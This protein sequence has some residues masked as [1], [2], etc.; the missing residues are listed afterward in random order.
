MKNFKRVLSVVLAVLL[1]T[2]VFVSCK[3]DEK[4]ASSTV[5]PS[6]S[7]E[8]SKSEEPSAPAEPAGQVIIGTDTEPNGDWAYG[9]FASSINATDQSVLF[10]TDDC[11]TVTTN[12]AGDYLIDPTIV[13]DYKREE[14]ADGNVT[15]TIKIRQGLVFNNGDP[16][17]AE[18][19]LAWPLFTMSKAG[20]DMG[21]TVITDSTPGG[22]DYREGK[23]NYLEGLR[24]LGDYEF[25][26]KTLAV[27]YSGNEYLPYYFDITMASARA[28][29]LDYWFGEGWTVKDDGQGAYLYNPDKELTKESVGDQVVAAQYATSDR[30]TA[31]PYNLVNFDKG[32]TEITLEVNPN[33]CGTFEGRKPMIKKVII[34]R[35]NEET[36]I[37]ELST[38][39]VEL[40]SSMADGKLV[41]SSLDLIDS[42]KFDGNY[43]SY[44]RAGYGQLV[45]ACDLG[46]AQYV[47]FR[48]AIAYLLDRNEFANTFC[49][50]WGGVVHG[51][52]CPAFTMY[53]DSRDLFAEKLNSYDFN[54]EKAVEL[55]KTA[56]FVFNA[57]G[58][59]YVDGSG[60]LRYKE[61]TEE[62][63]T[64][65]DEFVVKA[66]GKILMPALINWCSSEGNEVSDLLAT[67][68]A[69]G[70]ETKKAGIQIKQNIMSFPELLNYYY[71]QDVY[72][73]GGDYSV[74]TYNMFN[75]GTGF[76]A[77]YDMS[78]EFTTDP[79]WQ[80]EGYNTSHIN[81]EQ[82]DKLSMNMVYGVEA[83]DYA[84][85]LKTWQDFIIRFNEML[86]QIPLYANV[87]V[88]VYPN[89]IENYVEYPFW[90]FDRAIVYADYV[91]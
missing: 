32:A 38:G 48:Q 6:K 17:K 41:N 54:P 31:G 39:R 37:D 23:V 73:L 82:L 63:A 29:N 75:M 61:V 1:M 3:K 89:T 40:Y 68:L 4:P 43:T 85:Y 76:N 87:Y 42:G 44:D 46:P 8:P 7:A 24:L 62:E 57:D 78:Y 74:P 15:Y 88:S 69:N 45:F 19:F 67:M 30:V 5:E 80:A 11:K 26:I 28:V 64:H 83:G 52:Y 20:A 91:G 49:Q 66:G 14:D 86:P 58:T 50:G 71:R 81:D 90:G 36:I 13:E 16:I 21:T 65:Y 18:N 70:E 10:L 77:A 79:A 51:P 27:G 60:E 22:P 35:A 72:G 33:Y 55:L 9:A 25:S 53:K 2:V 12:Q 34:V 56:G 59:D 47:E 84:T